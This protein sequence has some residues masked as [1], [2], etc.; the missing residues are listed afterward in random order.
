VQNLVDTYADSAIN[1]PGTLTPTGNYTCNGTWNNLTLVVAKGAS[2]YVPLIAPTTLN[3]RKLVV[4]TGGNVVV[5]FGAPFQP[6]GSLNPAL[7]SPL[8]LNNGTIDN[9]GSFFIYGATI[10]DGSGANLVLNNVDGTLE[11]NFAIIQPAFKNLG[12]IVNPAG[13]EFKTGSI[14]A[15]AGSIE[16]NS[17]AATSVSDG[18]EQSGDADTCVGVGATLSVT[19]SYSIDGGTVELDDGVLSV[20]SDLA[21]GSAATFTAGGTVTAAT[22]QDDGALTVISP[23]GS[24][25]TLVDDGDYAQTGSLEVAIGGTEAGT[26]YDQLNVTGSATLG[27]NLVV[28]LDNP[29]FVPDVGDQFHIVT[30]DGCPPSRNSCHFSRLII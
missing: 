16:L 1:G 2:L 6:L 24:Y 21:L 8:V 29:D 15:S 4:N 28:D 12:K 14:V 19:G 20:S 17:Q 30:A 10:L 5:H 3:N 26:G 23:L 18:L 9:S 27:G 22:F 7:A 13:F 25:D 11:G